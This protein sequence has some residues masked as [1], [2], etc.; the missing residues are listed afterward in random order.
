MRRKTDSSATVDEN[1]ELSNSDLHE[2]MTQGVDDY[3]FR[4]Q[5]RAKLLEAGVP[6][7]DL[8]RVL[9]EKPRT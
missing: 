8:D 1:G 5:T 9:P 6:V 2:Q 3:E 4:M 7:A